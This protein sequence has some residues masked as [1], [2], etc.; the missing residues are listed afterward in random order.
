VLLVKTVLHALHIQHQM[1]SCAF[2]S[3]HTNCHNCWTYAPG[4]P[5]STSPPGP[6]TLLLLLP[7][8]PPPGA[9]SST[10]PRRSKSSKQMGQVVAAYWLRRMAAWSRLM[11][12]SFSVQDWGG[13]G[14]WW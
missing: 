10:D 9:P 6:C 7:A 11:A 2:Y 13:G 4:P 14:R 5:T 1:H 3:P 8:S 12:S